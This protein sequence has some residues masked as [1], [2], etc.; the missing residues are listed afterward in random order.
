MGA[1]LSPGNHVLIVP[2]STDVLAL[3]KHEVAQELGITLP[4]NGYYGPMTARDTGAIGGQMTRKLV[5]M[6]QHQMKVGNP[7]DDSHVQSTP[8]H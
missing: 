6:A 5:E 1:S 8:Q 7:L 4:S 3:F 2:E